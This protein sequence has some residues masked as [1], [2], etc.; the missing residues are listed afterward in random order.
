[1]YNEGG[2]SSS[3]VGSGYSSCIYV[4]SGSDGCSDAVAK[5]MSKHFLYRDD[6]VKKYPGKNYRNKMQ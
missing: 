3:S 5:L 1:M 2:C 6:R 4:E